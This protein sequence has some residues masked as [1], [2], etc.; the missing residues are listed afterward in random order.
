MNV[1]WQIM[2]TGTARLR[3]ID[4]RMSKLH[5]TVRLRKIDS[6]YQQAAD[7]SLLCRFDQLHMGNAGSAQSARM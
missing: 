3:K 7:C 4:R 5:I 1:A 2:A 6:L